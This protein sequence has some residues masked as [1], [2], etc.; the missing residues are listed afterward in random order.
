MQPILALWAVPRSTST[1]FER[2]MRQRGD[3][4]CFHEPFGEVWYHGA[5]RRVP[6]PNDVPVD[7]G[8]SFTGVYENICAAAARGPVFIKEFPHYIIHMADTAF[9][10]AFQHTF[11]IRDPE[12]TLPSMYDKWP[13][14]HIAET[15]FQE[16]YVLFDRIAQRS[17]KA[18]PVIDAEEMLDSPEVMFRAYCKA[19]GL[20]FVED[21]LEWA[22]GARKGMSWYA[23][24][25]WHGNL[26][27]STGFKRQ[28]RDYL[29]VDANEKLRA[30]H[31][32]C[33]PYY[34]KLYPH[35]I[36]AD[37]GSGAV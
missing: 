11:L 26:E 1:A 10:D 12:K 17:G 19:A 21:A 35:R 5:E 14:F 4:Q 23:G 2:M 3:M 22:P 37:A 28:K 25:S 18:P 13:D 7:P 32:A 36:R 9:M 16:Q 8:L 29:P 31:A 15:G 33:R 24:G 27:A 20:A 30:A 6:R 34:E